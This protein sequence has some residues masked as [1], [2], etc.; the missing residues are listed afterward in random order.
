MSDCSRVHTLIE[1]SVHER[2]EPD[3]QALLASHLAGCQACATLHDRVDRQRSAVAALAPRATP[4][5]ELRRAVLRTLMRPGPR[6]WL[7]PA[8]TGAMAATL[9]LAVALPF[10]LRF[11]LP[12]PSPFQELVSEAVNDHIRVVLRQRTGAAGPNDPQALQALMAKVLDYAVPVPATGEGPFRLAGGRPSYVMDQV[13]ACFYYQSPSAYASLFIIP[14]D[15]LGKAAAPFATLPVVTE[16]GA[17]RFAYWSRDGSAYFLVSEAPT[18]Q[19]LP[20]AATLRRS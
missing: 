16:Y 4:P 12:A 18:D 10:L 9:L 13:I 15:R 6:E 19:I 3:D 5:P 8:L 14:L 2:L 7:R 11:V 17:Y 1:G 20:L